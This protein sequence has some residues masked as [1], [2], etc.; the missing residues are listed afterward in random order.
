MID[1]Q[2]K[3]GMCVGAKFLQTVTSCTNEAL[4]SCG[5]SSKGNI[6]L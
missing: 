6:I 1:N 4:P 5:T 2:E 3:N